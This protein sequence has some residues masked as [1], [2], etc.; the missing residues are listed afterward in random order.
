MRRISLAA[1]VVVLAGASL[2]GCHGVTTAPGPAGQ[3]SAPAPAR[4]TAPGSA[5]QALDGLQVRARGPLT[6]YTRTAFGPA[7][8]DDTSD[9]DGHNGCDTRDDILARDLTGVSYRSGHCTVASGTLHD[10]YTGKVI[11]FVRGPRS[12]AVE[13]DHVVPLADA[14]GAGAAQLTSVRRMDLAED[15]LELLAVDGPTN[16]AK[17]DDDASQW[18]PPDTGDDCAYVARQIAV[19][20]KYHL[21]VTPAERTA[22]RKV[23]TGCPGQGVPTE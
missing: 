13:I 16:E 6:G 18:L 7:W 10:P 1:V 11:H 8:S 5:I 20:A 21:W 4:D 12:D 3:R 9:P 15:P 19:K 23:L 22:M 2:T 14:W 17:G